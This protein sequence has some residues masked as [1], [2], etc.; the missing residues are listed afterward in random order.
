[1]AAVRLSWLSARDVALSQVE[2]QPP[3]RWILFGVV[4]AITVAWVAFALRW[5]Y[6]IARG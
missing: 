5:M 3:G 4:V 6:R 1:M 2:Q